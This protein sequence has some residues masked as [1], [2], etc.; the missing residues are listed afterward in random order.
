MKAA[1]KRGKLRFIKD[2]C[3]AIPS[4]GRTAPMSFLAKL[5][6]YAPVLFWL[7]ILLWVVTL[8]F[9]LSGMRYN[10]GE[11]ISTDPILFALGS[12]AALLAASFGWLAD[13]LV[14]LWIAFI[15]AAFGAWG[16]AVDTNRRA[17]PPD[18]KRPK[19]RKTY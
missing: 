16:A 1:R 3:P 2:Y 8:F 19:P 5:P 7:A 12:G 11:V 15:A 18:S 6:G 14:M 17:P 10:R 4:P 9:I 13:P